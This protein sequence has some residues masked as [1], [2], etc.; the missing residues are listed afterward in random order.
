MIIP[1][2]ALFMLQTI[3]GE[4]SSEF[5]QWRTGN[6]WINEDSLLIAG[7]KT[8]FIIESDAEL[9]IIHGPFSD[10]LAI[11]KSE[12][13]Y[14]I[15][16]VK[17]LFIFDSSL[18]LVDSRSENYFQIQTPAKDITLGVMMPN[19]SVPYQKLLRD[20]SSGELLF[21]KPSHVNGRKVW[22]AEK[23]GWL[24]ALWSGEPNRI[25]AIGPKF[26][27]ESADNS[28]AGNYPY[29]SLPNPTIS[30]KTNTT[31]YHKNRAFIRKQEQLKA[32]APVFFGSMKNGFVVCREIG[33]RAPSLNMSLYIGS[34][35]EIDFLNSKGEFIK[36]QIT[37]G[38]IAG[39][40][41]DQLVVLHNSKITVSTLERWRV[42][43]G[44][45]YERAQGLLEDFKRRKY[46][47]WTIFLEYFDWPE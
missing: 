5:G 42:T 22:V 12:D 16:D 30:G 14:F 29:F 11:A 28:I 10:I 21:R 34:R 44:S 47:K 26:D 24:L 20:F 31:Y 15:S 37:Y 46:R 43:N 32:P 25:F 9:R 8:V 17:G 18:K 7:K 6:P 27:K 4:L 39:I 38:Q 3:E 13:K 35:I 40:V 36:K 33:V 19:P 2:L 41:N 1:A 23:N 45:P